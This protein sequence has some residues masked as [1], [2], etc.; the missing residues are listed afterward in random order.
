M[1][2]VCT[3]EDL[4]RDCVRR[5]DQQDSSRCCIAAFLPLLIGLS[6]SC[7]V[8]G[9]CDVHVGPRRAV[10]LVHDRR[11]TIFVNWLSCTILSRLLSGIGVACRR[12]CISRCWWWL[13]VG[14]LWVHR[15]IRK[16]RVGLLLLD[17]LEVLLMNVDRSLVDL[18]GGD[19]GRSCHLVRRRCLSGIVAHGSGV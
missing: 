12:L 18:V 13:D 3:L 11:A 6:D 10:R 14:R 8:V 17:R 2:M 5:C 19:E 4:M 1:R 7:D 9:C 16:R 15:M